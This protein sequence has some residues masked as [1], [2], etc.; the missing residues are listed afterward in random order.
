MELKAKQSLL[1]E[2]NNSKNERG[3]EA[4]GLTDLWETGREILSNTAN[5]GW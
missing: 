1:I 5:R 4:T 3:K 2:F